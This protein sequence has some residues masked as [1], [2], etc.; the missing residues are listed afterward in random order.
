MSACPTDSSL[1]EVALQ[2]DQIKDL[3]FG[4]LDQETIRHIS[5]LPFLRSLNFEV[6]PDLGSLMDS[7][8]PRPFSALRGLQFGDTTFERATQFLLLLSN[9]GLVNFHIGAVTKST[10]H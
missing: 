8:L 9:C 7:P 1:S 4:E 6:L 5:Q 2:L 10:T 3:A